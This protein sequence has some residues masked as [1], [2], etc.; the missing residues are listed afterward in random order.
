MAQAVAAVQP[1]MSTLN[2]QYSNSGAGNSHAYGTCGF[3]IARVNPDGNPDVKPFIAL[4]LDA[5]INSY[6]FYNNSDKEKK[7]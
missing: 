6:V 7:S 4:M 5:F 3:S 1:P 2:W